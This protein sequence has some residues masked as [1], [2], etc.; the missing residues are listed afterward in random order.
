MCVLT[1]DAMRPLCKLNLDSFGITVLR[2]A[3]RGQ[4]VRSIVLRLHKPPG[5]D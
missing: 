3:A 4:C 1:R 2:F 5:N